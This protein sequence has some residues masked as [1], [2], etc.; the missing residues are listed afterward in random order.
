[1][2]SF[3]LVFAEESGAFSW[4][5]STRV[6]PD[7]ALG[8]GSEH[9]MDKRILDRLGLFDAPDIGKSSRY[10]VELELENEDSDWSFKVTVTVEF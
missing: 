6:K 4:R 10:N 7:F 9:A 2:L 1:M 5:A 8:Y 3:G